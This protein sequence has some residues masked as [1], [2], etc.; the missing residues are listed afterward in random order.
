MLHVP[1][2]F[3]EGA[4]NEHEM[5]T[6]TELATLKMLSMSCNIAAAVTDALISLVLVYYL[7]ISKT[8]FVKTDDMLNRLIASTFNIGL[9][10][11]I[12][13]LAACIPVHWYQYSPRFSFQPQINASPQTF[14]YI[15]WFLL[16]ANAVY[17]NTLLVI[18]NTRDYIRAASAPGMVEEI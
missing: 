4:R 7:Y 5:N 8:G 10:T 9:P 11:S 12:C 16:P 2:I 3:H 14:I 13:A 17:T 18:L 6:Y 15:F 1:S